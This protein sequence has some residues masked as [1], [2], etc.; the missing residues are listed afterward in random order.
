ME[1]KH[2]SS[3]GVH[4]IYYNTREQAFVNA[5]KEKPFDQVGTENNTPTKQVGDTSDLSCVVKKHEPERVNSKS[6]INGKKL[7]WRT[8]TLSRI[9]F[10]LLT[11]QNW[12]EICRKKLSWCMDPERSENVF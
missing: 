7:M 9:V 6:T 1:W 5:K 8:Q 11:V 12:L 2:L 4:R 10:L 3:T